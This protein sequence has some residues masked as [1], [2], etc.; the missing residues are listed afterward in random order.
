MEEQESIIT[1]LLVEFKEIRRSIKEM[2]SN[3]EMISK[4]IVK[5]FPENLQPKYKWLFEERVKT[6]TE[7][8]RTLLE[9]RKEINKSLK[10]EMEIRRR[11]GK[12][13]R[14]E[15][16]D[17]ESFLDVRKIAKRVEEFQKRSKKVSEKIVN[18]KDK[19]VSK[20]I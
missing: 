3:L 19:K 6:M 11:I 20:T 5:I 15:D 10:D 4:D 2:V 16:E 18:I 14:G 9:M 7:T 13:L 8:F 1:S 17:L 12:D